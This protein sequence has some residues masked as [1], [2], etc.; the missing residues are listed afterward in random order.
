MGR[1]RNDPLRGNIYFHLGD[2]SGF[3][4]VR[5]DGGLS[6]WPKTA[7]GLSDKARPCYGLRGRVTM[8]HAVVQ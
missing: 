6:R 5:P 7:S 4:A 1:D 3:V 2:D 8:W